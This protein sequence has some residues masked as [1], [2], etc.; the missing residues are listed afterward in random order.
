M[1]AADTHAL[2]DQHRQ[3]MDFYNNLEEVPFVAGAPD[4]EFDRLLT[5]EDILL[6]SPETIAECRV[7]A[8]YALDDVSGMNHQNALRR[9]LQSIS[10]ALSR[11]T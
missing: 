5:L 3:Q 7:L 4:I 9:V 2:I 10:R 8:D 1:K 11:L 6:L